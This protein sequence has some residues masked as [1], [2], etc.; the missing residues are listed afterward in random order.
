MSGYSVSL[1][2]APADDFFFSIVFDRFTFLVHSPSAISLASGAGSTRLNSQSGFVRSASSFTPSFSASTLQKSSPQ[3]F[4]SILLSV[5]SFIVPSLQAH[6]PLPT[7]L[8]FPPRMARS[9]ISVLYKAHVSNRLKGLPI[10]SMHFSASNGRDR[11]RESLTLP[12]QRRQCRS[13]SVRWPSWTT[14][15]LQM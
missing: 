6:V 12:R 1:I 3:T 9:F 8:S 2:R 4:A 10:P 13:L 14:A 5:P 15:S 7:L 11:E